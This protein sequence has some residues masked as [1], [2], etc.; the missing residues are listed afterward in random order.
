MKNNIF[1]NDFIDYTGQLMDL[2]LA[3][4]EEPAVHQADKIRDDQNVCIK[5][6]SFHFIAPKRKFNNYSHGIC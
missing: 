6:K 3:R 4:R 1:L 5:L 2:E